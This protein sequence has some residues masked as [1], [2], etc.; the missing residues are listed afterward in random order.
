MINFFYRI[1]FWHRGDE[2][3]IKEQG[4]KLF[5]CIFELIFVVSL[6]V[7]AIISDDRDNSILLAEIGIIGAV[8]LVKLWILIWNQKQ[9][10]G[11]INRIC[12]F[13]IRCDDDCTIVN[14]KLSG[15]FK[16]VIGL[17]IYL[18]VADLSVMGIAPFIGSEKTLFFKVAFPLDWRKNDISFWVANIFVFTGLLLSM[19]AFSLSITV[20]Y[21]MLICSLRYT[22]LGNELKKMGEISEEKRGKISEKEKNYT[23]L[24][25]LEESIDVHFNMRKYILNKT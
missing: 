24:L 23:F 15:F 14:E 9:I 17:L 2:A 16:F 4:I 19:A 18:M 7:G 21:L 25:D 20:W 12:I 8:L 22:E 13:S 6:L 5:Y 3:T 1:G 10:L 11:L